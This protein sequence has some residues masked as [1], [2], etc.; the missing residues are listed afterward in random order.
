M[1]TYVGG[2]AV[3][4]DDTCG[5]YLRVNDATGRRG[6][7]GCGCRGAGG[8]FEELV[9]QLACSGGPEGRPTVLGDRSW[10]WRPMMMEEVSV[11]W[12][13]H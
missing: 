4:S 2:P 10:V 3:H 6:R 5:G 11:W 1:L 8:Y 9:G 13:L 12:W 7:G